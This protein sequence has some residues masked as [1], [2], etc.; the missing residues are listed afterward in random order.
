[1]E[2]IWIHITSGQGPT[3]CE[4]VVAQVVEL[5]LEEAKTLGIDCSLLESVPSKDS[6]RDA[7]SS[8]LLGATLAPAH[9]GGFDSWEGTIQWIG[10]STY[11]PNHK[12]K[13]WFVGVE[14]LKPPAQLSFDEA[15]VKLETMRAS[16]AGGQH[17]NRTES[18]VRLTHLPTGISVT[19]QEERSQHMNKKLAYVVLMRRLEAHAQGEAQQHVQSMWMQHHTL[20]RG[21]AVRVYEGPRFKRKR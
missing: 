19:C 15:D 9:A 5:I 17:V 6:P 1:M 16:G 18:A 21:D 13:N 12:R 7:I 2:T 11:R 20:V 3:E 14:L 8:A 4:W 10:R